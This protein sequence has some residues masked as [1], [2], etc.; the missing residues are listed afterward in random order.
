MAS[1]SLQ[2][3]Y[4]KFQTVYR[5]LADERV[6]HVC[7]LLFWTSLSGVASFYFYLVPLVL[8]I[9][10]TTFWLQPS[11]HTILNLPLTWNSHSLGNIWKY[12]PA[13]Q[14]MQSINP[15]WRGY[16]YFEGQCP[17][18]V[19]NDLHRMPIYVN[20]LLWGKSVCLCVCVHGC[21]SSNRDPVVLKLDVCTYAR[22]VNVLIAKDG[23]LK[24]NWE[25]FP[26]LPSAKNNF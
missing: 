13:I 11:K 4:F 23:Q 19:P 14:P 8:L 17:L 1:F 24:H 6:A 26:T 2:I 10:G 15:A 18:C 7:N 12:I 22:W 5:S 3:K 25:G 21:L 20:P 16:M 9:W